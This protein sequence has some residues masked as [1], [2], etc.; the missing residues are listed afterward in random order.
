MVYIF[1]EVMILLSVFGVTVILFKTKWHLKIDENDVRYLLITRKR[2]SR[3]LFAFFPI[4]ST[5]EWFNFGFINKI[6]TLAM[7]F[8]IAKFS[9]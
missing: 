1:E 6:I 5:Y 7:T 2:K 3:S 8:Q 4:T 9:K